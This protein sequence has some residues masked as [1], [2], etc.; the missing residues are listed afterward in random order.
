MS[1]GNKREN[2]GSPSTRGEV[3]T[4]QERRTERVTESRGRDGGRGKGK[5]RKVVISAADGR[6]CDVTIW[7]PPAS[8]PLAWCLV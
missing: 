3:Y 1:K 8:E 7:C 6:R 5:E 4:L 2:E